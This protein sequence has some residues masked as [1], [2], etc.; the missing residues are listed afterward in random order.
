MVPTIL[1]T[2]LALPFVVLAARVGRRRWA[3]R[4]EAA[5]VRAEVVFHHRLTRS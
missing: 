2:V 4:C 1:L 5:R 3:R